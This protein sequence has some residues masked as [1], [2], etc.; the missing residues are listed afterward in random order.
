MNRHDMRLARL[1]YRLLYAGLLYAGLLTGAVATLI[2]S[3]AALLGALRL[4]AWLL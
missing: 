1:L 4:L 3:A 2:L